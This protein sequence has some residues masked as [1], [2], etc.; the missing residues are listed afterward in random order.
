M[1]VPSFER[2]EDKNGVYDIS[3][4]KDVISFLNG[5]IKDDEICPVK[6]DV[7]LSFT[8][9]NE[10]KKIYSYNGRPILYCNDGFGDGVF[11]EVESVFWHVSC[12]CLGSGTSKVFFR[13]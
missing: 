9:Q 11:E 7:L 1:I 6:K 8:M 10:V 13:T 5:C 2:V 12:G 3:L 4:Y